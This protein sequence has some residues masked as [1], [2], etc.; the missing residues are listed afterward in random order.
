VTRLRIV[1]DEHRHDWE[2]DH[3]AILRLLDEN[4]DA[5]LE[6]LVS[7]AIDLGSA[8]LNGENRLEL[9]WC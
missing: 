7:R 2:N 4:P 9:A 5:Q 3:A 6:V 1:L 8:P